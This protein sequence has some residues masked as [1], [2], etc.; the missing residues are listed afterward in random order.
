MTGRL[1]LKEE[2][3]QIL[4]QEASAAFSHSVLVKGFELYR[5]KSVTSVQVNKGFELIGYCRGPRHPLKVTIDLDFFTISACT[6]G[7]EALCQHIAAVFWQAC[8]LAGKRPEW[9][10]AELD[11]AA[12]HEDSRDQQA[13]QHKAG[14]QEQ[15]RREPKAIAAQTPK[16]GDPPEA[17]HDYFQAKLRKALKPVS[18]GPTLSAFYQQ[19]IKQLFPVANAW[20]PNIRNVYRLHV[21]LFILIK[22]QAYLRR[23]N[24][25]NYVDYYLSR[26]MST[27]IGRL[28][29]DLDDILPHLRQLSQRHTLDAGLRGIMQLLA[30]HAFPK[31]PSL[32][33]WQG[34][35]RIVWGHILNY[36]EFIADEEAR[37]LK[38]L[39]AGEL[40]PY[41]TRHI[42]L[43]LAFFD[44]MNERDAKCLKRLEKCK[45]LKSTDV[46]GYMEQLAYKK[47]WDRL[48]VWLQHL[49]EE[50]RRFGIYNQQDS[51]LELW[52]EGA[53]A[54]PGNSAWEE[55]IRTMLPQ[56]RPV[57]TEYLIRQGKAREVVH[58]HISSGHSLYYMDKDV[59]KQ[60]QSVD[61][62]L[63]LPLYHQEAERAILQKNREGYKEAVRHLKK[64]A[65]I[66]KKLKEQDRWNA[67]LE[68]V[69]TRYSRLR[70]FQ[71]E[72]RKGKLIV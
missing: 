10:L 17:W 64:L 68:L 15:A 33:D 13:K 7:Q 22:I 44:F 50:I 67:Y 8:E 46:E 42:H 20:E 59:L 9:I 5:N 16:P 28:S 62:A 35:Y 11:K 24:P 55:W 51:L 18:G 3:V 29:E 49:T 36:A 70:A 40:S 65:Q 2:A 58:Q 31:D 45:P 63:L 60:I 69:S 14:Q 23:Q 72:L 54:Q 56:A 27:V 47:E 34:V 21:L 4:I 19:A 39:K 6:C 52:L 38:Q 26:E 66:Y 61:A 25:Y 32:L 41:Q 57:Y 48:L 1:E 30:E 12:L 37:L 43:A 53:L 71:E